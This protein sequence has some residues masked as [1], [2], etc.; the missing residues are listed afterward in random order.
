MVIKTVLL[1][2]L[3]ELLLKFEHDPVTQ[4]LRSEQHKSFEPQSMSELQTSP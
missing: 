3:L 2:P 1:E 4:V